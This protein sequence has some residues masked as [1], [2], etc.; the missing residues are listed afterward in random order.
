MEDFEVIQAARNVL[1]PVKP[2]TVVTEGTDND[3]LYKNDEIAL[4]CISEAVNEIFSYQHPESVVAKRI[5]AITEEQF[6]LKI[7]LPRAKIIREVMDQLL[8]KVHE[9][10]LEDP[11]SH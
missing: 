2:T 4:V 8:E 10:L 11:V 7:S 1:T 6:G 3:P 9:E 5:Q